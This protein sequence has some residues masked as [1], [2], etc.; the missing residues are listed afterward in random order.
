[1]FLSWSALALM[2]A[3]V[4]YTASMCLRSAGV[5]IGSPIPVDKKFETCY[6][7]GHKPLVMR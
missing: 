1:M 6:K 7:H 2:S 5:I 4:Q 3:N